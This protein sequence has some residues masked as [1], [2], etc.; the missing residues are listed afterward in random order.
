VGEW[1]H[2]RGDRVGCGGGVGCGVDR[3]WMGGWRMGNGIWS[4]KKIKN[5]IKFKN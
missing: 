4:V 1:G 5:K 3:R 2:P